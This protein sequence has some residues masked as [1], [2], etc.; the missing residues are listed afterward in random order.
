[1]TSNNALIPDADK[2]DILASKPFDWPFLYNGLRMNS[3]ADNGIKYYLMGNPA[4]WWGSS[5]SL[6]VAAAVILWY[7]GRMQR[8]VYD[9]SPKDWD[10]FLFAFKVAGIGW[11]LHF[12]PFCL[13][14]RV[15]YL[16]HYLPTLYFAVLMATHL[17]DHF[18]WNINTA[19]Y[20]RRKGRV[21]VSNTVKNIVF[22]VATFIVG[23]TFWLYRFNSYG[24]EGSSMAKSH[25]KLRKS[26]NLTD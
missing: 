13:F 24:L 26:W 4:I 8:R 15:E 19:I 2:D 10:Q 14:S 23:G 9:L 22:V 3:W 11:L 6:F 5:A 7:L 17:L 12:V 25:L 18:V 21:P 20:P 16:H 1:M